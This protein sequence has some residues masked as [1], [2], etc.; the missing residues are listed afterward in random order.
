MTI[1]VTFNLNFPDAP[2]PWVPTLIENVL[3]PLLVT[4]VSGIAV[5]I[6]LGGSETPEQSTAIQS[7]LKRIDSID[8][9]RP[10]PVPVP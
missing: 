1:E 3:V 4:P 2:P 8:P 7:L 9:A 10:S 6:N 5:T